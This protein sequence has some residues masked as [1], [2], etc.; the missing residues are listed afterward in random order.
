M[1]EDN[2]QQIVEGEVTANGDADTLVTVT[3][4]IQNYLGQINE[5]KRLLTEHKQMIE[6]ALNNDETYKKHSDAAKEATKVKLAT[7]KQLMQQPNMRELSEKV[8]DL[9]ADMKAARESLSQ[10]LQQYHELT[11]SNQF[12]DGKGEVLDIV[13]VAKLQRVRR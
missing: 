6:D 3:N 13:Y 9:T 10:Y 12:E 11:N 5:N 8:K 2:T 4:L 7:K 1:D